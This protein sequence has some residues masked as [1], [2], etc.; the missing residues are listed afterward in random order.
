MGVNLDTLAPEP[1]V[2]GHSTPG[3][4]SYKAVRPIAL[5]KCMAIAQMIKKDF[6]DRTLSGIGG[7]DTGGHAAD[8]FAGAGAS[9]ALPVSE[10]KFLLVGEIGV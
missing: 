3:G 1:C 8:C 4:Y 9:A 10:A 7:I 6:P 2:E 5:A